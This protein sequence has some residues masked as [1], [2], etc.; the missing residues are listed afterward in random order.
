M[1]GGVDRI[2]ALPDDLIQRILRFAPANEAASTSLLSARWRSLWRSTGAVNLAVRLPELDRRHGYRVIH[3]AVSSCHDAFLRSAQAALSAAAAGGRGRHVTR[4]TLDLRAATMDVIDGFVHTERS[5]DAGAAPAP[6][7]DVWLR[8]SDDVER[9][10]DRWVKRGDVV[11]DVV[12]HPAARRVEE[13]RLSASAPAVDDD[14]DGGEVGR[15]VGVFH[16]DLRY[17]PSETLRVLDLTRCS[18]LRMPPAAAAA[19]ETPR[20]TTLRLQACAVNANDLQR[21]IDAAPALATVHLDSVSFDGMEHGCYRLRLPAATTTLV[22]ARCRTDAEPYRYRRSGGPLGTS[23]V[24]IDAPGLRSFRYAGYARR[25]SLAS[26]PDMARA[27]LHFFHDMYASASTC[28]DLFWRFLRN[29][30]GVRSLK[31]KVSNL[32]HVAVAG[33]AATRAELLVAFPSVEHLELAGHHEPASEAAAAVAIGN[34]LRCCPA[35][36]HL[37]LRL[38]TAPSERDSAMNGR[39]GCDLLRA[40]QQADLAESLDRFARRR[41]RKPPPPPVNS[42][43]EHLN[44]VGLNGRS[45]ACLTNS[46]RRFAIQFR[47]DQPNCIGVKLIKFFAENAIHLEEMR[48]DG[49]NQ[50]MHDHINHMVERWISDS[51]SA[52]KRANHEI[53]SEG[54]CDVSV[55][56]SKQ[57]IEASTP[58]FR[59]LPLERR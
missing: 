38:T 24:E 37:A 51:S 7:T 39:Y 1:A 34:L 36:R 46:L 13:L 8:L 20:L 59:L 31:L 54:S 56:D 6:D 26:P 17:V 42:M 10:A 15:L 25:F 50:R 9:E 33:R 16:L 52:K 22:L 49:G 45:F 40:K 55:V 28:R 53:S 14:D 4:L 44:I 41:K 27:D 30:R 43:D 21:V 23:S 48:I 18:G 19:V 58:R 29:F 12:S 3:A 35:A 32:K 11:R 5:F 47:M 57:G 2:S